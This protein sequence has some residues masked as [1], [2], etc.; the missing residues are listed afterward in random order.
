MK[1][2]EAIKAAKQLFD[3][4]IDKL[5]KSKAEARGGRPFPVPPGGCPDGWYD[6]GGGN[7]VLD[8]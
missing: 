5:K 6:N 2:Q 7:C 8:S 1:K 3:T 4:E